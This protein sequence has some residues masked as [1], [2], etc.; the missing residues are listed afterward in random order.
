GDDGKIIS[1]GVFTE[2]ARAGRLRDQV[3]ALG[4]EPL[5][6]DRTRREDVYWIDLMLKAGR[7][8]DFEA[9]Q[10]PGR[11]TRLEQRPCGTPFAAAGAP[12][13]GR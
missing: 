2:I 7:E 10:T 13:P 9:L 11:I 5:V 8:V 6:V 1:L 12:A 4:F 3:R